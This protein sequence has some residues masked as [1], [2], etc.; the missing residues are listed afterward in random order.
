MNI[1]DLIEG[2]FV[3]LRLKCNTE[4]IERLGK[5]YQIKPTY[6]FE[7]SQEMGFINST[8]DAL[9]DILPIP[10]NNDCLKKF[11]FERINANQYVRCLENGHCI[12][13]EILYK[14]SDLMN[15]IDRI[16]VFINNRLENEDLKYVHEL[17]HII[18]K[19]ETIDS[20]TF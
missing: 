16:E 18:V 9:C 2:D 14:T 15:V 6:C 3:A 8:D 11:R 4:I 1:N 13:I 5:V 19:L 10:L 12:R 7:L 17:Q 20:Q